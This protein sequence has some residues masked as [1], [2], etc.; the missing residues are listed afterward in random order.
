M[1]NVTNQQ[2][3]EQMYSNYAAGNMAAVI[4]SFDKAIIWER[5]GEPFIPFSG[6]FT[7]IDAV[8]KMFAIQATSISIKEFV[9][10]QICVNE[11]TV[12]VLGHDVA[13]VISTNKTYAT[14]WV[15]A[16]T[17]SASKIIHV[18]VYMDTKAIAD[19]FLP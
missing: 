13:E 9:P 6:T 18:Q 8:M 10:D 3:I 12:S 16:F 4:S 2:V 5:A 7:G 19:A 17:F 11:D 1:D 15:E 14:K